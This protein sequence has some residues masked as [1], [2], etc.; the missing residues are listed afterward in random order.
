MGAY[1]T[2]IVGL[3]RTGSEVVRRARRVVAE[4][5][6]ALAPLLGA[7]V[8]DAGGVYRLTE[9]GDELVVPLEG[10]AE[11][12][13]H[14]WRANA[15]VVGAAYQEVIQGLRAAIQDVLSL[16]AA[17]A[18][19]VGQG[20]QVFV[21]SGLADPV[22]SAALIHVLE[23]LGETRRFFQNTTR[24]TH[25]AVFT[26][27]PDSSDR[28][29]SSRAAAVV[30][31][32]EHVLDYDSKVGSGSS[33]SVVDTTWAF[34]RQ[35]ADGLF[36]GGIGD[37]APVFARLVGA[38]LSGEAMSDRS[39][40]SITQMEA[41]G[42]RRRYSAVGTARLVFPRDEIVDGAVTRVTY[43]ALRDAVVAADVSIP[44]TEAYSQSRGFIRRLG[45]ERLVDLLRVDVDERE[46]Y[47]PF[48]PKLP[49]TDPTGSATLEA[50]RAQAEEYAGNDLGEMRRA[51]GA[52]RSKLIDA[53]RQALANEMG[54]VLDRPAPVGAALAFL[55]AFEGSESG[56][57]SGEPNDR[58]LT[59]DALDKEVRK[60]FDSQFEPILFGEIEDEDRVSYLGA[61]S[62][63][64]R[65][66]VQRVVLDLQTKRRNLER[67]EGAL[68]LLQEDLA[69]AIEAAGD[70]NE[71]EETER[72][73]RDG[74]RR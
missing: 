10:I 28:E 73:D 17:G 43:G 25:L 27:D 30:R 46:I 6:P 12:G 14:P 61:R 13:D 45:L 58:P 35:N 24:Q 26:H 72:G 8:L 57:I 23:A 7:I 66:V 74:G 47:T 62:L 67:A 60:F 9:G 70:A 29:A 53:H 59:L 48:D 40:A 39:Y 51:L 2:L 49:T 63:G 64:R 22:G 18:L 11:D 33:G 65:E 4:D 42:R 20:L 34:S 71:A 68:S 41:L 36:A 15:D 32:L 69:K 56:Y 55:A 44:A 3:G 37:L 1:P 21:A 16:H 52:R 31:E 50:I 5:R 38:V 19:N 54:G